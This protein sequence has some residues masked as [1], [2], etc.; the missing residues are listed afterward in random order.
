MQG[1]SKGGER[2]V[3]DPVDPSKTIKVRVGVKYGYITNYDAWCFA[4]LTTDAH[5]TEPNATIQVLQLSPF[6]SVKDARLAFAYFLRLAMEDGERT[7][8]LATEPLPMAEATTTNAAASA[9][10]HAP[11]S[12]SAAAAA[13]APPAPR[14]R[15]SSLI[16]K[17]NPFKSAVMQGVELTTTEDATGLSSLFLGVFGEVLVSS[18]KSTTFRGVVNGRDLVWRQF[19]VYGLPRHTE[20]SIEA[21]EDALDRELEAYVHLRSQWR[22]LVPE[23]VYVGIDINTLWVFV[24]TYEGVSLRALSDKG[25][26]DDE[27]KR[28]ALESLQALH[29]AGVVHGDAQLRNVVRR[30]TDGALLWV[31]LEMATVRGGTHDR[32]GGWFDAAAV[33]ETRSFRSVLEL[34]DDGGGGGETGVEEP[35]D[36]VDVAEAVAPA[37]AEGAAGASSSAPTPAPTAKHGEGGGAASTAGGGWFAK[38]AKVAPCCRIA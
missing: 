4:R 15:R 34:V 36:V 20:W 18:D 8:P 27:T 26:L 5:P 16:D 33:E 10:A 28:R 25:L 13:A 14:R 19:D 3:V 37:A 23:F 38:R 24:T 7:V 29:E 35:A 6:Y 9:A 21:L 30:E 32:G 1:Y 31:D 17:F 11:S 2:E 12:S 22:R